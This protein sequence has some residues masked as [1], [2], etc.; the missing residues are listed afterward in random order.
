MSILSIR[1]GLQPGF[2]CVKSDVL[3]LLNLNFNFKFHKNET[4]DLTLTLSY[5]EI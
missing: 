5:Q 2:S 4:S 3:F 1:D